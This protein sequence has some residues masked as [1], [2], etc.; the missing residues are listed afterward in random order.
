MKQLFVLVIAVLLFGPGDGKKKGRQGN[1]LYGQ[2]QYEEAMAAYQ[3][4][5]GA[6]QEDGPGAVHSGL[7]NNLGAA[8]YRTGDMEQAGIAFSSAATMA[9][10]PEDLVRASYN[11]GNAAFKAEQLE[12]ALEHYRRAL[13]NDPS[14]ADAKFN[15]EFVKRQLEEQ[16]QN[17]EQQDQQD[18]NQ[19][20]QENENNQDQEGE[21][22]EQ[23]QEQDQQQQSPDDAGQQQD[24]QQQQ[25]E[26]QEREDPTKL[27]EEEA[28]R[29]LQALENEE[30]QLLRQVQKMKTRPRRVEKDW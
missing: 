10:A 7:L 25:Q 23:Q 13:L 1:A 19:E 26:Q 5:V 12:Q 30:E 29:I 18:E 14:N 6:V 20:N 15:Y 17:Q 28:Q 8:L 16:Q 3:E 2:E 11:A 21:Q 22:D 4:G 24:Q 9:L 27:S